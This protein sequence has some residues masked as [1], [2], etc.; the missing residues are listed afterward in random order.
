VQGSGLAELLLVG[1]VEWCVCVCG[2]G[3]YE[4]VVSKGSGCCGFEQQGRVAGRR[5]GASVLVSYRVM[6][7]SGQE[8]ESS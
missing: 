7:H 2:G 5:R 8:E 1:D 4:R 3:G 6:M